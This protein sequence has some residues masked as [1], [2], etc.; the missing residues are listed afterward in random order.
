MFIT[1]ENKE[2]RTFDTLEDAFAD[3]GA[4]VG[5]RISNA[6]RQGRIWVMSTTEHERTSV[7]LLVHSKLAVECGEEVMEYNYI[8]F[9]AKYV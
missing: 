6:E 4:R 7:G 2:T 3:F 8:L 5:Y 1:M 9:E